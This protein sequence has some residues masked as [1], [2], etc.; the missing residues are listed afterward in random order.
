MTNRRE[1]FT[2][3]MSKIGLR[4]INLFVFAGT[5]DETTLRELSQDMI[6]SRM[7]T[8]YHDMMQKTNEELYEDDLL[9][10][11]MDLGVPKGL[12]SLHDLVRY[13]KVAFGEN[14]KA[15][16]EVK[17]A[18][19]EYMEASRAIQSYA[20]RD[21]AGEI[22]PDHVYD[23]YMDNMRQKA[24]RFV[25]SR[26]LQRAWN[27]FASLHKDGLDSILARSTVKE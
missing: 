4:Q 9:E 25:Y 2:S 24:R 16:E 27:K 15:L 14:S 7:L 17:D 21:D 20:A 26:V 8:K 23:A 1:S 22:P 13:S 10:S 18:M 3:K 12:P 6:T 11:M 5:D 19:T